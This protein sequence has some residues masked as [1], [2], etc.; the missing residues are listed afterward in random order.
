MP[1]AAAAVD[2]T[3]VAKMVYLLYLRLLVFVLASA[4]AL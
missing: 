1:A 3:H 4:A 2:A